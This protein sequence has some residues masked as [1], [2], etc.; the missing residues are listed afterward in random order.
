MSYRV[1]LGERM[2]IGSMVV[3]R[4]QLDLHGHRVDIAEVS[5]QEIRTLFVR[6]KEGKIEWVSS[7][8]L[9]TVRAAKQELSDERPWIAS[10]GKVAVDDLVLRLE[11]QTT[12][13]AATQ[14]IDGFSLTAENLS[15][16][17]GKKG[18]VSLKSRINQKG[19]LKVDGSVQLVPLQTTLKVETQAIPVLP[20]Q[21]YFTD[22]LNIEL[23]RGQVSNSGEVTA[24]IDKDGVN[25]SYKG[26]LTLGDLIAVNKVNN[27]DFLKWKSLYLGGIDVRLQPMAVN[28]GE[29]ALSDF[30]SR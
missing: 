30:Y 15:T 14:V 18:N 19:S 26:S 6:N 25:A 1:D 24:Q 11:D 29:V 3:K 28:V 10:I 2:K 16:E 21:P 4:M 27:A 8:V 17:P 22:F 5:S 7:P 12:K 20:L 23:M 9:K 13:P